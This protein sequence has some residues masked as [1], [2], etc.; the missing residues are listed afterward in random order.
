MRNRLIGMGM[1]A[2][3]VGFS[4]A[5]CSSRVC[6]LIGCYDTFT[7]SVKRADGSFPVG[8]H[9]LEVLQDGVTQM[10]T[11]TFA[12]SAPGIGGA[13]AVCPSSALSVMVANAETCVETHTGSSVSY[14]CDPIAGQFIET[15]T[16]MGT[17]A[18]VHVWQYVDDVAIVD[19]AAAPSYADH[20]PNGPECGGAC[21]QASASWTMQ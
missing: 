20:F 16:L 15:I 2:A 11:F 17:P 19:A 10:C 3:W 7:A 18:Q 4:A 8:M 1:I 5:A 6:T 14:R 9:R 21:R 12:E 13:T